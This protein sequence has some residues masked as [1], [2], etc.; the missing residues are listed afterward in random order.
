MN[1]FILS[2]ILTSLPILGAEKHL[3]YLMLAPPCFAVGMLLEVDE[4]YLVYARCSAWR[5][6]QRVN[7][8]LGRPDNL[9]PYALRVN[10]VPAIYYTFHSGVASV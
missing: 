2:I 10:L 6:A 5:S 1:A 8:F 9:F 4:Q 3:H 7:C